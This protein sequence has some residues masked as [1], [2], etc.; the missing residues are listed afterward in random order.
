MAARRTSFHGLLDRS[1]TLRAMAATHTT[2]ADRIRNAGG[3]TSDR[4]RKAGTALARIGPLSV[5]DLLKTLRAGQPVAREEAAIALGQM[6]E[7]AR[8]AVPELIALLADA[9]LEPATTH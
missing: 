7:N 9:Q 3:G 1:H 2:D 6:G 8:T 4:R 5:S